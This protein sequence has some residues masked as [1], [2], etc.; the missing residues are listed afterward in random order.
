[1]MNPYRS[2]NAIILDIKR[3]TDDTK[4]YTLSFEDEQTQRE[5]SS[6]PGQFIMVSL[7]GIGE[8]AFSPCAYPTESRNIEITVRA[9]GNVTTILDHLKIGDVV[10]IRG[11][12][13]TCWPLEE[14]KKKNVLMVAGG[15]GINPIRSAITYVAANRD[16]YGDV[17]ILYGAKT[18]DQLLFTNEFDDWGR[19]KNS[20]LLLTVDVVPKESIWKHNVGMVTSLFE[21]M[22]A[23][24]DNTIA[25][26]CGPEI[27]MRFVVKGLQYRGFTSDQIFV[28]LERRMNCGI[29]IC[30]HCQLG[31]KFVCKEGPVFRYAD[32]KGLPDSM[33]G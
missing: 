27:M 19:R 29:G 2:E 7:L 3:Q 32:V 21:R 1:M 4:T 13:G 5:F 11:P 33:L 16:D 6:K 22:H 24:P 25:L 28:S 30:G 12:Y 23:R 14:A 9:V 20:R 31:T 15:L 18:P 26:T 17:E 10:G 8:A